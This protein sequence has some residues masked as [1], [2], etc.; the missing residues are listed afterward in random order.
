M[1]ARADYMREWRKRPKTKNAGY[2][3]KQARAYRLAQQ[4]L[5]EN[6]RAEFDELYE[7]ERRD[8]GLDV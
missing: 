2:D 8:Q 5:R 3:R 7:E 1:T 4:R 6:H